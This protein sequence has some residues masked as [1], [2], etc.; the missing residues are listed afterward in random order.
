[1]RWIITGT[2]IVSGIFILALSLRLFDI[3]E[4]PHGFFCDEADIGYNGYKLLQTGK[5]EHGVSFPIF[6]E[7]FGEYRLPIPIYSTI[8][9]TWLF[10]LS[11]F[12]VRFTTALSGALT[13]L[14]FYFIGKNIRN[15]M[16]GYCAS[17]LLAVSPWHIHMSR[18]GSEYVSFPLFASLG[19][20]FFLMSFRK[21]IWLIVSLS[22]FSLSLYTYYPSWAVIPF[23]IAGI[24][25]HWLVINRSNHLRY[26]L[27]AITCTVL[28]A[29][30]LVLS[31]L[32]GKILTRWYDIQ[33][34]KV[35]MAEKLKLF[36]QYYI[37]HFNPEYLFVKGDLAYPGRFITR[38]YIKDFG[39]FYL[40]QLP[41]IVVGLFII[42]FRRLKLLP[43]F[44]LMLVL[45]PFGNTPLMESTSTTRSIFGLIPFTLL[46]AA[47]MAGIF[48]SLRTKWG[49]VIVVIT[50]Q[51]ILS[52]FHR[53]LVKYYFLYPTY[54]SDYWGW[55]YG[56]RDILNYFLSVQDNYDELIMNG[57]YNM[58]TIFI[59]FYTLGRCPKCRVSW[60]ADAYD[61]KKHQLFAPALSELSKGD[62]AS[63]FKT[64]KEL[65][66]PNGQLA[67]KIGEIIR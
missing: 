20:L 12:S 56:P 45:Y 60:L 62:W 29:V 40:Y 46:S 9:S 28:I 10:G 34:S 55:Q 63:R 5:D 24:S 8:P 66:Y 23:L 38:Q 59:P 58:P 11:E 17:F 39:Y 13:V 36:P 18:W 22:V 64:V 3:T 33:N 30:P 6:F 31:M 15:R 7:A 14:I 26:F 4:I 49:I 44:I 65:Y 47:G 57:E 42:I 53:Y 19:F 16:T 51:F 48:S 35:T 61:P 2:L 32:N 25:I 37:E 54:S 1:M 43:L 41:L 21:P 50:L 27:I 67:V 52:D